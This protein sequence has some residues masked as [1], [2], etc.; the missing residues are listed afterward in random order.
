MASYEYQ[1]T[2][3]PLYANPNLHV[4][5]APIANLF[6]TYAIEDYDLSKVGT[7][8]D[9]LVSRLKRRNLAC[10]Y[11]DAATATFTIGCL[12]HCSAHRLRGNYLVST[13]FTFS[14]GEERSSARQLFVMADSWAANAKEDDETPGR[15]RF[16]YV[17]A[18]E[19]SI[20]KAHEIAMFSMSAELADMYKGFRRN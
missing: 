9:D 20:E 7:E 12:H 15:D 17:R 18:T 16:T 3:I 4:F 19:L 13:L 8:L 10:V 5:T 1:P 11:G 2:A 6:H 14:V